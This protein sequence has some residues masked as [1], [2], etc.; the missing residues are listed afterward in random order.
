MTISI[1]N[2]YV[3]MSGCDVAKAKKG[4]DPHP[5]TQGTKPE[6]GSQPDDRGP[7]VLLGGTLVQ[8]LTSDALKAADS[9]AGTDATSSRAQKLTIDL[10][11]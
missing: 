8:G 10:L 3:C 4:E 5:S 11:A 1:V 2:G 7:A 9:T 6:G